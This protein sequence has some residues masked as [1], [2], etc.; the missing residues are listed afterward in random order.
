MLFGPISPVPPSGTPGRKQSDGVATLKRQDLAEAALCR[1]HNALF[2]KKRLSK[3]SVPRQGNLRTAKRPVIW[4]VRDSIKL[5]M[6]RF[7]GRQRAFQKPAILWRGLC[8]GED[9]A[10]GQ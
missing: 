2:Q 6:R 4:S 10:I 1:C 9:Q 3:S 8:P 7:G 5:C